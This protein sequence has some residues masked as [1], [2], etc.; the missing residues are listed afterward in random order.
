MGADGKIQPDKGEILKM[1][2]QQAQELREKK[3]RMKFAEEEMRRRGD[4]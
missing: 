2:E 1:Q 4:L 3:D